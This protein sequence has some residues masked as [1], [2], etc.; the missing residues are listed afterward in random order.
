MKPIF[1]K[2][3]VFSLS[4]VTGVKDVIVW[5]NITGSNYI[6]LSHAKLNGYD[7]AIRG[8]PNFQRPLLSMI[9]DRYSTD[10]FLSNK[11]KEL[12][13]IHAYLDCLIKYQYM[14][15]FSRFVFTDWHYT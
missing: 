10:L 2:V 15:L 7:C 3:F 13:L 14:F 8:P 1:L 12:L 5:G 9:Y 6:D 4:F 11:I